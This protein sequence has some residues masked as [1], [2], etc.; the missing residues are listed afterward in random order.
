MKPW[1]QTLKAWFT[2]ERRHDLRVLSIWLVVGVIIVIGGAKVI[3]SGKDEVEPND[4]GFDGPPPI[5]VAPSGPME[6]REFL[7]YPDIF[8]TYPSAAS[9]D[10]FAGLVESGPS[11]DKARYQLPLP[12][13]PKR[14]LEEVGVTFPEGAKLFYDGRT[15]LRVYNTALQLDLIEVLVEPLCCLTESGL[16]FALR[17]YR[18]DAELLQE[19]AEPDPEQVNQWLANGEAKLEFMAAFD[20]RSGQR[21]KVMAGNEQKKGTCLLLDGAIG[22]DGYTIDVNLELTHEV[23]GSLESPEVFDFEGS[24][25]T[26]RGISKLLGIRPWPDGTGEEKTLVFLDAQIVSV[27]PYE[28]FPPE[29]WTPPSEETLKELREAPLNLP[30]DGDPFAGLGSR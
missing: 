3:E 7:V 23:E 6:W 30:D 28:S 24:F 14:T 10:P 18:I 5:T 12:I 4:L 17:V 9:D 26:Y 15:R 25:V 29:V 2:R 22:P 11:E 27:S 19:E 1:I 21:S 8:V 16:N 20:T 13:D